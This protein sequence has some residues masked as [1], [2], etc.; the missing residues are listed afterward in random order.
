MPPWAGCRARSGCDGLAAQGGAGAARG[1]TGRDG[2]RG[3][4]GLAGRVWTGQVGGTG[5]RAGLAREGGR[6]AWLSGSGPDGPVLIAWVPG[7]GRDGTG[8][9]HRARRDS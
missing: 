3:R 8:W 4:S 5:W 7:T 9:R 1:C 2:F 6:V